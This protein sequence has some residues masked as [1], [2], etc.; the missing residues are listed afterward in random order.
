MAA[1]TCTA[2]RTSTNIHVGPDGTTARLE[3]GNTVLYFWKGSTDWAKASTFSGIKLAQFL[4]AEPQRAR[5]QIG[6]GE[7]DLFAVDFTTSGQKLMKLCPKK[8]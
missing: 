3:P 6:F 8:G 1:W 4:I 5:K 2:S 7:A